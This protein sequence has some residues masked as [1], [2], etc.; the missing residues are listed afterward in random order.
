MDFHERQLM[1]RKGLSK[2]TVHKAP[3][4]KEIE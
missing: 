3:D 2:I 4:A 1:M